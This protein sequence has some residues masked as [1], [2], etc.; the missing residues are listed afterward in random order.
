M[1]ATVFARQSHVLIVPSQEEEKR[2]SGC[3]EAN[4]ISVIL[5]SCPAKQQGKKNRVWF[6]SAKE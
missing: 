6:W 1:D 4:A 3:V 2:I 5:S